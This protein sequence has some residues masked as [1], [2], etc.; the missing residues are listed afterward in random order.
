VPDELV[1]KYMSM[2]EAHDEFAKVGRR[3]Y[4]SRYLDSGKCIKFMEE[5]A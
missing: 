5:V 1:D 4:L 3:I 2:Y